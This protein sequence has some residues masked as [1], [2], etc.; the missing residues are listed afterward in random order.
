MLDWKMKGH[1]QYSHA[2]ITQTLGKD[3]IYSHCI[4]HFQQNTVCYSY[5]WLIVSNEIFTSKSHDKS[6]ILFF[7]VVDLSYCLL[8]VAISCRENFRDEFILFP[9]QYTIL[10]SKKI[11]HSSGYLN[12]TIH[13]HNAIVYW[14]TIFLQ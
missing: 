9:E 11:L 6:T 10:I 14:R 1:E 7:I 3:S 5:G 13:K 12:W 4:A 8:Y 2:S